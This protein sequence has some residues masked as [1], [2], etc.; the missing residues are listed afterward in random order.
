MKIQLTQIRADEME[1][2][3]IYTI[4]GE[5][6]EITSIAPLWYDKNKNTLVIKAVDFEEEEKEFQL[7]VSASVYFEDYGF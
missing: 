7:Y 3:G 2:G 5:E 4:N 6:L 1:V